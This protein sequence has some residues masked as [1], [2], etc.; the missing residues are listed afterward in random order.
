MPRYY[1]RR[2][3]Y[4]R[5]RRGRPTSA[6]GWSASGAMA[7]A[8]KAL[9]LA[10][11]LKSMLNVEKKFF[12]TTLDA[13]PDT[14]GAVT[15]VVQIPS[16]EGAVDQGQS[17]DGDQVRLK[18]I[19]ASGALNL[20]ASATQTAVRLTLVMDKM[21]LAT[22]P[23]IGDIFESTSTVALHNL[24]NRNRFV[25]LWSRQFMLNT[26]RPNLFF[27]FYKSTSTKLQWAGDATDE[28][29]N[30]CF[31]FVTSSSEATNKPTLTAQCRIRFVDN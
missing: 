21:A 23:V 1:R 19:Q 27:R 24:A 16:Q 8:S 5:R 7:T 28:P 6:Q 13:T 20:H 25:T 4:G 22:A 14:T 29:M 11:G 15:S 18:S 9:A 2:R 30:K 31:Y 17:R 10:M 26:D 12:D 3:R